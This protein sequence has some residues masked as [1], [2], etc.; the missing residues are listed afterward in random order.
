L[1]A[2]HAHW[3]NSLPIMNKMGMV[4][5]SEIIAIRGIIK[6]GYGKNHGKKS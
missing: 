2:A 5:T 4:R 3:K 1:S 6:F